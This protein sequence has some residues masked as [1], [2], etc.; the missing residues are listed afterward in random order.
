MDKKTFLAQVDG[1]KGELTRADMDEGIRK[2]CLYCPMALALGRMLPQYEY[3]AV[4]GENADILDTNGNEVLS[5]ILSQD[6]RD[7]IMNYDDGQ[8]VRPVFI[9]IRRI[10]GIWMLT[11]TYEKA[12]PLTYHAIPD[13]IKV[14]VVY[15]NDEP[16][17]EEWEASISESGKVEHLVDTRGNFY[18]TMEEVYARGIRHIVL[19]NNHEVD[20]SLD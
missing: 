18:F 5:L 8:P 3:I 2:D 7:W 11:Q 1:K 9:A 19:S 13:A 6:L 16:F 12:T 15:E 14:N 4:D 17:G 20:I 10:Y